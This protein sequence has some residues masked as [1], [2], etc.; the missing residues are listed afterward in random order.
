MTTPLGPVQRYEHLDSTNEEALRLLAAGQAPHGLVLVATEQAAGRGRRGARWH[1]APGEGLYMTAIWRPPAGLAAPLLTMATGLGVYE[2]LATLGAPGLAL[3]WPNDLLHGPAKLAGI[4]VETRG[5]DP[6]HPA[7]AVGIGV[8]V[9]QAG[10]PGWLTGERPV[11][12]LRILGLEVTPDQ[13][14]EAL[15]RSLP[16]RWQQAEQ[17]PESLSADYLAATGLA[18]RQV[19]CEAGDRVL[20]ARLVGLTVP[21]GLELETGDGQLERIAL[22]WVRALTAL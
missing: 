2:G 13:V 1:S 18:G 6:A 11:T 20:E 10:F 4:L 14:L 17:D 16:P 19:R 7:Y 9:G 21:G 12:S 15:C 5:M 8:N 22:E 3:K